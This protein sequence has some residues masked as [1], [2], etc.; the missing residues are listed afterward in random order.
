MRRLALS[1]MLVLLASSQLMCSPLHPEEPPR[2]AIQLGM[3]WWPADAGNEMDS[4]KSDMEACLSARLRDVA[5]EITVTRRSVIR[6][7]LFPL[8]E[9]AT[10]PGSQEAFAALLAR[11]DVR[12]RLVQRG[13]HY[14]LAISG[15]TIK[16]PSKGGILCGAGYGGGGCLGFS[17]QGKTTTLDAALWSLDERAIIRQFEGVKAAGTS[18]MPAFVF[19][20]PIPAHTEA[21]ACHELGTRIARSIRQTLGPPNSPR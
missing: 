5:P 1:L 11:E 3:V 21:Q 12:A 17:W 20:V 4:F 18:M 6:D 2:A 15:G 7:A 13:L 14:L 9:P 16:A 8:L 10:Q 19:P